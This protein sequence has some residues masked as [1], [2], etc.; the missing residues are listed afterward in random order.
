MRPEDQ[1]N[2]HE[3]PA[4]RFDRRRGLFFFESV[5][6]RTYFR[7]TRPAVALIT[8][9][10]IIPIALIMIL[11]VSRPA[12]DKTKVDVTLLPLPSP[13][14]SNVPL[15]KQPPP[16]GPPQTLRQPPSPPAPPPPALEP[17]P[18]AEIGHPKQTE[19]PAVP[20]PRVP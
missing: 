19:T 9:F 1:F 13:A 18:G 2:N 3:A 11:F 8:A 12:M 7:F 6:G 20:Q 5:G 17:P 16:A 14:S 10:I 4:S 15:I